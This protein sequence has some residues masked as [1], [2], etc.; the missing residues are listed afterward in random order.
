[1]TDGS[2]Y[3]ETET[4]NLTTTTSDHWANITF[5]GLAADDGTKLWEMLFQMTA[6]FTPLLSSYGNESVYYNISAESLTTNLEPSTWW[7]REDQSYDMSFVHAQLGVMPLPISLKE[8]QVMSLSPEITQPSAAGVGIMNEATGLFHMIEN[9]PGRDIA[10]CLFCRAADSSDMGVDIFYTTLFTQAMISPGSPAKALQA[11][12]FARAREGYYTLME[13]FSPVGTASVTFLEAAPVPV[14]GRGY[15]SVVGVL[16]VFVATFGVVGRRFRST[17]NSLPENAWHTIAQLSESPEISQ[18]LRR[19]T[20]A[21]DEA[22]EHLI[23][24]TQPPFGSAG[25]IGSFKAASRKLWDEIVAVIKS[26]RRTDKPRFMVR[27]GVFVRASGAE[28]EAD[29]ESMELRLRSTTM[30][31]SSQDC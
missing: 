31:T 20:L 23:D 17:H 18:I 5:R 8:R 7:E 14:R 30:N 3:G 27:D 15:W 4:L 26:R 28:K 29:L 9:L 12:R 21:T 1:M 25:Q 24:G 19:S 16:G 6:C 10:F 2:F 13:A 22:V 11:V